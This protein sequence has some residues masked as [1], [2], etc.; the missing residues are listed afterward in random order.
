MRLSEVSLF[1]I[2]MCSAKKEVGQIGIVI[3]SLTLLS[4]EPSLSYEL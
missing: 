3:V 4:H 2:L 1:A